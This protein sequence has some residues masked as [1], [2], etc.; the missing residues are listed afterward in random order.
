MKRNNWSMFLLFVGL[1]LAI[2]PVNAADEDPLPSWA[3]SALKE[4]IVDFV[5]AVTDEGSK[6][7]VAEPL[8]VAVFDNDGTLW[9]EKP[10]YPQ[11]VFA[12]DRAKSYVAEHPEVT[13]EAVFRAAVD[14][15]YEALSKSGAGGIQK[16]IGT[17]HTGMTSAAFS[18]IVSDWIKSA[19]HPRFKRPY[20]ECV[21]QPML[22]LMKYFRANG[23]RTVIVSGGGR[24]FMR[25]WSGAT[26]GISDNQVIGSSCGL[27]YHD[28]DVYRTPK[29][30][31]LNDGKDKPVGIE[32]YLGVRPIAAFGNSD[33]DYEMLD[34]T[35]GNKG[36]TLCAIVHHTDARREYAYDRQS[37]VGHLER[38]LDDSAKKGWLLIDMKSDW[39]SIFP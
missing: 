30:S 29:I 38:A 17:T 22:E 5:N 15:D 6:D 8:R 28:G 11:M 26:Y 19:K 3:P 13:E 27:E 21:Y 4:K 25:P 10:I 33:G 9:C 36:R 2:A 32:S 18:K 16:L 37:S 35:S 1:L 12:A 24:D 31:F 23:F 34:W 39:K 20:T 7:F 14:K